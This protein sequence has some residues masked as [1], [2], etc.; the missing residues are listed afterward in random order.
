MNIDIARNETD[1]KNADLKR[2]RKEYSGYDDEEFDPSLVGIKKKV[3]SKYDAELD[4]EQD[5]VS[6]LSSLSRTTI[7]T[8]VDV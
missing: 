4:G 1:E 2:K 8:D 6:P 5:T 7:W 3:L